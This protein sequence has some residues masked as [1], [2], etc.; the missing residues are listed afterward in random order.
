MPVRFALTSIGALLAGSALAAQTP[1]PSPAAIDSIF[2]Q[3]NRTTSPGCALGVFQRERIVYSR[4][5]G[6]ADLNQG[7]AINPSTV[8]YVA[9]TSKQ[10]TALSI[11]LLA[12]QGKIGL[13]DPVRKWIPELPAYADSITI[14]HLVHHTSGLRDYLGLWGLSGR[15]FADEIPEEVALD[16]IV[17]QREADFSPGA[18]W[19]YSNSGYFLLSQIVKR[20]SGQSL[21]EFAE[22]AI[23]GPLGMTSTHWHDDNQMI[24]PRRAEGYQPNGKGG[25]QIVRTSFALVGDGGLLT[26]V[27]DLARYDANFYHNRLGHRGQ[28]LIDQ[29][30]TPGT[31]ASGEPL[32]YA[33]GLFPDTHRGLK[34]IAHGGSFI[35][36]RAE[37]VRFP[38]E[39]L[40]VAVLC[41]DYTAAPEQLAVRVADLYL[42][43]KLSRPEATAAATGGAMP[44][45][46]ALD[47]L[48]GRYELAPGTIAVIARDQARLTFTLGPGPGFKLIAASD[49]VFSAEGFPGTLTFVRSRDGTPGLVVSAFGKEPAARL[50]EPPVLTAADR[51]G[52][53]G[54]YVSTELDTWAVI[55]AAGDSLRARVRF[56]PWLGLKPIR[57]DEFAVVGAGAAIRFQRDRAGVVTGY[58]L[59]AARSRNI[60]FV[61]V[62]PPPAASS[63]R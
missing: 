62:N 12:E 36:Y 5:Y 16:L 49:S 23:F 28:A 38:T 31:L 26:T 9:S 4:G 3:Y 63:R 22:A 52:L 18:K 34:T 29:V 58:R 35:G 51:A 24:V 61:R 39:K 15:S 57:K 46:E 8:F 40:S 19:S 33:F 44:S 55:E 14:R 25:F 6:M 13:D 60:E 17:R 7:I 43:D 21:R 47:R 48:V 1:A 41:N 50:G 10:F 20:A 53:A 32:T 59:D 11:A 45:A 30:T 2:A 42:A 56:G 54:R 37:L 27:E